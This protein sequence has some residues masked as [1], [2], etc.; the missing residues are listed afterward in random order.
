MGLTAFLLGAESE[1]EF[2]LEF[3]FGRWRLANGFR[4]EIHGNIPA[5]NILLEKNSHAQWKLIFDFPPLHLRVESSQ[6]GNSLT[7][8]V[9][10]QLRRMLIKKFDCT[11]SESNT[12]M[13]FSNDHEIVQDSA[14]DAYTR[15][16]M[17]RARYHGNSQSAHAHEFCERLPANLNIHNFI[18]IS[19]LWYCKMLQDK[20]V[21]KME[22]KSVNHDYFGYKILSR[23]CH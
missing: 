18:T 19:S 13:K 16:A 2:F 10:S 8:A 9:I 1:D 6:V 4:L 21:T 22:H 20:F 3:F 7:K 5:N 14:Q 12:C 17:R 15:V 23:V 11:A